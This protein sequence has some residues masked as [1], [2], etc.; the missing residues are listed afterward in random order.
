MRL[1]AL[2]LF[3]G[4]VILGY[5]ANSDK[6]FR[7]FGF[8]FGN[9]CEGVLPKGTVIAFDTSSG[10]PEDWE[11]EESYKGRIIIGAGLGKSLTDRPFRVVGGNETHTLTVAE[12]P[13]HY[14]NTYRSQ[15]TAGDGLYASAPVMG[16]D[17][18]Q[19]VPGQTQEAGG[20][21]PHNIMPPFIPLHLC[22]KK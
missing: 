6:C 2:T 20:N 3:T 11:A 10:C 12:L 4:V 13:A 22:R 1:L 9:K 8:L 5:S 18:R 17:R 19:A 14:H 21:Q 7:F 15:T 16:N